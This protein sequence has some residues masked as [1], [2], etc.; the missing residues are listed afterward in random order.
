MIDFQSGGLFARLGPSNPKEMAAEVAP[1]LVDGETVY[2]SFKGIRDAVA[3]T[4][5]RL[6]T[7]NVQGITGKSV[8]TR[9]CL[10]ASSKRGASRLRDGS[11]WTLNLNCG[12]RGLGWFAWTSKDRSTYAQLENLSGATFSI[13]SP[14]S[15]QW[16]AERFCYLTW[17]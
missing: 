3:F 9:R 11:I 12:S 15:P 7:V 10:T 13:P 1:L 6:I 4:N 8:T 14:R 5:K 2:L 17:H 16:R